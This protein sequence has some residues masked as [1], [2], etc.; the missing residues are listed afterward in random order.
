LCDRGVGE[1]A[2]D[3][4]RGIFGNAAGAEARLRRAPAAGGDRAAGA[5]SYGDYL[6]LDQLLA[7]QRPLTA[8][9]DELLFVV[10]HQAS[11]LWMKLMIH[12]LG[13]AVQFL[14]VDDVGACQKV[15]ARCKVI[16][17]QL[18]EM[19]SV[20]E[21]LTPADYMKFRDALGQSSGFQSYQYRTIEFMLGNK[22]RALLA[23]HRHRADLHD[24][25]KAALEAPSLYDEAIRLLAREG[26]AVDEAELNRDV[27]LPRQPNDSV[28]N[29]WLR[30]YRET[31]KDWDLYELAEE[32]VDLEDGFRQWRFRHVTT[33]E[34]IIGAKRGTGGTA[35]VGYLREVLNVRLFPELWEL[36]TEL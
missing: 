16:L 14:R 15:I 3:D 9:H 33:V 28:R 22:N 20:L 2:Q 5:M 4:E 32:L 26:F 23:P 11:E 18:T 12:E 36:R 25:L 10:V 19:W 35:G 27:S 34:R 30:V 17:R 8:H 21:T 24:P 31:G 6:A 29:A 1:I 13:A 7:S